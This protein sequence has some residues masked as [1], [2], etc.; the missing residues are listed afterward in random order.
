[1]KIT[2]IWME[3]C[4]ENKQSGFCVLLM[5]VKNLPKVL[6]CSISLVTTTEGKMIKMLCYQFFSPVK[7]R[8]HL[9]S[10]CEIEPFEF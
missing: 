4:A 3:T 2:G 5:N 6:N 1:M 10:R 7:I 8:W 9:V